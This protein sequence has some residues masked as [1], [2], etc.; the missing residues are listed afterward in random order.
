MVIANAGR[1]DTKHTSQLT[2][3]EA[4]AVFDVNINGA[5]A[6][7][8]AAVPMMIER[9]K[10]QLVGVSSVAGR[11]GLPTSAAYSAS[12]AALAIFLESMRIDLRP[13]GIFVTDIQPGFVTTPMSDKIKD[14]SPMPFV[15]PVERA[16]R[17]IARRLESAPAMIAFPWQ[18]AFITR[19]TRHLPAWIYDP[20][21]RAQLKS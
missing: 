5:V 3:E 4:K 2:Y 1:G 15:W 7:L 8:L 11:R 10:G 17:H 21:I 9:K 20:I 14:K 16:A 13:S 18:L 19:I 12:K 6:T